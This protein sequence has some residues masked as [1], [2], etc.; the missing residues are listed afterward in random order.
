MRALTAG[1]LVGARRLGGGSRY[2]FTG[3]GLQSWAAV[4]VVALTAVLAL[5]A[6]V[7]APPAGASVAPGPASLAAQEHTGTFKDGGVLRYGAAPFLGSPTAGALA[8]PVVAMAST[9]DGRGYW[10]VS[11]DG[12]VWSYGDARYFGGTGQAHL[13]A[14]IVTMEATVDGQGYWLA[15]ANGDI[16]AFGDATFYGPITPLAPPAPIVGLARTPDGHG[17]W[18]VSSH[19]DVY[20]FGDARFYG[21]LGATNLHNLPVVAMAASADGAG[22]WLVQGG[23]EVVAYGDAPHLGGM[24][25]HPPVVGIAVT[26]DGQGYWLACGNGEVD[27]F[28]DAAYLG[29][30]DR[31][32]PRPP[33]AGIV[34]DPA[35]PGYWLLDAEAFHVKLDHPGAGP[36][37]RIVRVAASQLGPSPDGGHYCNPY[38]PCEEW[39]ALFAT[40]VW[41]KAGVEVPRFAF[42]GDVYS[43]AARHTRVISARSRPLPGDIVLYG[44]G[45]DNVWTS[46]H[47]GVVAQVWPDGEIDTVEGDAGPGPGA[48]TSVLVNG[49]YLPAQSYFANGMPIYG[50][51]VP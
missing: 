12:E 27:A 47:V 46:P 33:I 37:A 31:A 5:R 28:G 32:V 45:P 15:A 9:P 16:F 21:S 22:Y 1:R 44:T 10:L 36:W 11:A 40:W 4:V 3:L 34:A 23:G 50:Y 17:Y 42:A 8:T 2:W 25:G 13:A 35:S 26:A 30:N 41:E 14:P 43:W 24:R 51:A 39:C 48:W 29:A 7:A 20:S 18:M 38:G 49:P 6:V 19:G